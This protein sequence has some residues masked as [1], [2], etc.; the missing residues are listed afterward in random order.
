[1]GHRQGWIYFHIDGILGHRKDKNASKGYLVHV[2]WG[3]GTSTWNDL[4]ITFQDDP[5]TVSLYAQRNDLLDTPGWKEC[6]GYVKNPKKLSRM[7]NQAH[8]KCNRT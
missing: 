7:I 5:I 1:M 6:R 2:Q 3:D 4:G 8:L